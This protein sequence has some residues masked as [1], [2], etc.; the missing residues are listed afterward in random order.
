[1]EGE[2]GERSIE[3]RAWKMQR[4]RFHFCRALKDAVSAL[5][6]NSV[7]QGVVR[8]GGRKTKKRNFQLKHLFRGHAALRVLAFSSGNCIINRRI[9]KCETTVVSDLLPLHTGFVW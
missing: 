2:Q 9:C 5:L 4:N 6:G 1:M 7:L 8:K 3:I